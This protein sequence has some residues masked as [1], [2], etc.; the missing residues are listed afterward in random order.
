MDWVISSDTL[1]SMAHM[2][3]QRRALIIKEKLGMPT[4][5]PNTVRRWYMKYGVNYQ[6]PKYTFW[7][8]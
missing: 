1:H 2:S 6:R 8:S 3:L 5:S 7:K 4:L